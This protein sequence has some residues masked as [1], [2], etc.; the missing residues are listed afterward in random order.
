MNDMFEPGSGS[1]R[2][3]A[4]APEE[5][6]G[7]GE[8]FSRLG[9]QGAEAWEYIRYYTSAKL[10]GA[11][12]SVREAAQKLALAIVG[13]IVAMSLMIVAGIYLVDGLAE[14]I[15]LLVGAAWLGKLLAG[16][17]I[18]GL[19]GSIIG[20]GLRAAKTRSFRETR[21]KYEERQRQQQ[22]RFGHNVTH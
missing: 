2:G 16:L 14:G 10:D 1:H 13:G 6:A 11:K 7:D 22:A 21:K 4:V 5:P 8:F 12:L 19:F 17:L 9:K 15:G 18:L 20:G 3:T